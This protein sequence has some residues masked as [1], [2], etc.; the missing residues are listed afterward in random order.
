MLSCK[1][2]I[3]K[4]PASNDKFNK[5][6]MTFLINNVSAMVENKLFI[7]IVLVNK[8]NINTVQSVGVKSTPALICGDSENI[9]IG[10]D[11]II[12][13]II[14]LCE[15]KEDD[16]N[17]NSSKVKSKKQLEYDNG[18]C[19]VKD[20]LM[21]ILQSGDDNDMDNEQDLKKKMQERLAHSSTGE[22][23]IRSNPAIYK[24]LKENNQFEGRESIDMNVNTGDS[25]EDA[26]M[27]KYWANMEETDI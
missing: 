17:D 15:N 22:S 27:A 4:N 24:K 1:I 13:K 12:K 2:F 26:A 23:T 8:N 9:I 3:K 20:M 11:N 18:D 6:L 14:S 16:T 19:D 25:T 21:E 10:I 7:R 5:N